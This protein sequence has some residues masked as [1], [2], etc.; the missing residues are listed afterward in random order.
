M[1][2]N[3][4]HRIQHNA[5]HIDELVQANSD[6]IHDIQQSRVDSCERTYE[7]IREVFKPFYPPK[8]RTLKQIQD[9]E[10]FNDTINNLKAHCVIQTHP[11]G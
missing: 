10:T 7:G 6:R 3:I 2:G 1:F 9:L 4:L 11:G 8:P 5:H